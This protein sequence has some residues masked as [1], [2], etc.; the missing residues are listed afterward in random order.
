MKTVYLGHLWD[1]ESSVIFQNDP[2]AYPDDLPECKNQT[3][4]KEQVF[5]GDA[6]FMKKT[7]SGHAENG[8]FIQNIV[9]TP[10]SGEIY[11]NAIHQGVLYYSFEDS[12][13]QIEEE[14]PF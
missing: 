14:L 6:K 9:Y 3:Y 11:Q 13:F 4:K 1:G 8:C 10:M 5:I 2:I 12:P 7:I